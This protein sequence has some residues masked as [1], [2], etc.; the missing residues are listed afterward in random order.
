[1]EGGWHITSIIRTDRGLTEMLCMGETIQHQ[2]QPCT[3]GAWYEPWHPAELI[4]RTCPRPRLILARTRVNLHQTTWED[5]A[6]ILPPPPFKKQWAR[7]KEREKRTHTNLG[8]GVEQSQLSERGANNC[9]RLSPA[10]GTCLLSGHRV[11][12]WYKSRVHVQVLRMIRWKETVETRRHAHVHARFRVDLFDCISRCH[13]SL[14]CVCVCVR[15]RGG[16]R[17][18]RRSC[19]TPQSLSLS[20]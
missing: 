10:T 4:G 1:M 12:M 13:S 6:F 5:C 2:Q 15:Q 11:R 3:A 18:N 16:D 8:G 9:W 20:V 7:K 19:P 14:S 17:G